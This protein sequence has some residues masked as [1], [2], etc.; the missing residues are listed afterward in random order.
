M[1]LI[2]HHNDL[3]KLQAGAAHPDEQFSQR[4]GK[5]AFLVKGWDMMDRERSIQDQADLAGNLTG[6]KDGRRG[7]I[8]GAGFYDRRWTER[9]FRLSSTFQKQSQV[10]RRLGGHR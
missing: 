8:P 10:S 4:L 9:D 1:E 6:N 5:P 2:I 7:T 3:N